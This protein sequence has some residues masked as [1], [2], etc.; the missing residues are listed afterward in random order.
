[1]ADTLLTSTGDDME[2]AQKYI[3]AMANMYDKARKAKAEQRQLANP[4]LD[5]HNE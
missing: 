4:Q 1:M 2:S 5:F 3:T